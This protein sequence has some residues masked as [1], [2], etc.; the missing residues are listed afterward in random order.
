MADDDDGCETCRMNEVYAKLQL[1]TAESFRDDDTCRNDDL[2][3][4]LLSFAPKF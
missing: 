2:L 3:D 4:D 1:A